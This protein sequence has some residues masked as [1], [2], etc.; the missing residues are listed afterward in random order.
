MK[1]LHNL[2]LK[3]LQKSGSLSI[4]GLLE[5]FEE[6]EL[7]ILETIE[8]LARLELIKIDIKGCFTRVDLTDLSEQKIYPN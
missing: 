6:P 5:R 1:D 8:D 3:E 2:L 4:H 7:A